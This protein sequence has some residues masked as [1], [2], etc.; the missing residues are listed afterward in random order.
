MSCASL[1]GLVFCWLLRESCGL[2]A[3][4]AKFGRKIIKGKVTK[5]KHSS[6]CLGS[7]KSCLDGGVL[8]R[9]H[10]VIKRTWETTPG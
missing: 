4:N 5:P 8:E 6:A 10:Y 9:M 2:N 1:L 7:G 3:E